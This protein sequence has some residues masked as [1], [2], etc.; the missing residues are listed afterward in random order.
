MNFRNISAWSIRNPVVPI[1]IFIGL[2]IAGLMSFSTMKVQN[3]PDIEFPAVIVAISQPGAAPSEIESQ[4]TQ[5]VES[6]VRTI[7][8]VDTISSTASEGGNQTVVTFQIGTDINEAVAEVKNA[9]D[10]ARGE[11]PDGILEPQIFK[12]QTSSDPIA[13]FA[14]SADD[15]TIEQ[16]S[17]FIDDTVAKELLTVEGMATVDR[18]GGVNREIRVT[19]DPAKM[20]SLGVTASQVNSALRALN[21]NAAGGKAEIAG[22]RQSVRVLGNA[23]NAYELSQTDVPLGG[24]RT[25]KLTDFAS[26]SDSFG[27]VTTMGKINGKPVVTFAMSRARGFGCFG[28]R[29]RRRQDRAAPEGS[30]GDPLHPAVQLGRLYQ[31][32][33]RK[34][35]FLDGRR[36]DP[37]GHRGVLLPARLASHGDRSD[38]HSAVGDP[39]VLDDGCLVRLHAQLALAARTGVGRRCAGR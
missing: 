32:A 9:V 26:V 14:V 5:K 22:S 28:L 30:P 20:Q 6:A 12:V 27:E 33:V 3:D 10:Q 25:V 17:W 18:Q 23:S 21:V 24:G 13:Y 7:N 15:M 29:R 35:D 2:M 8:G 4:I 31:A 19:L 11:L 38:R 16:L 34:L 39:D 1:V 36:R 37:R